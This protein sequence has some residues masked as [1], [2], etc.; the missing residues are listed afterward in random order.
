VAGQKH[1][2]WFWIGVSALVMGIVAAATFEILLSR[3]APILRARLLESLSARYH[4]R[5]EL[6]SFDVS[7]LRGFEVSGKDLAIYPYNIESNTPTFS[8]RRFAFRTGYA[9]LLHSPLHIGHVEVEGL[10]INLPPKSQRKDVSQPTNGH[11]P[12]SNASIFVDEMECTDT[13]LTLGTDKAGKL[14]LR[15]VIQSLLL[16]SVG[17]AK[18][19][20]FTAVLTNP[21]P[22]GQI[23][24]RGYF[25][26]WN[27]DRPGATPVG[28]TYSFHDADLGTIKGI[29]GILSSQ[30]KYV[31]TLDKIVVDGTTDTPDFQVKISGHKMP[32]HRP[33]PFCHPEPMTSP[34]ARS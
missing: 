33:S 7:L 18:P 12:P 16:R 1:R 28:G 26:P 24:S 9:G 30:G 23:E 6:G 25:G 4:S 5:V 34:A 8:V 27:T 32:L 31:G 2:A 29:G 3:A 10:R 20:D 22:V 15:F 14:P 19:M 21:K 11:H 13:V 17:P